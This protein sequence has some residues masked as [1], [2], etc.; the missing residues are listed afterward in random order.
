MLITCKRNCTIPKGKR[1]MFVPAGGQI[2]VDKGQVDYKKNPWL[3]HFH[4]PEIPK[5]TAKKSSTKTSSD[6][7]EEQE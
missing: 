7:K 6:S 2:E 5:P 4:V 3:K 1:T